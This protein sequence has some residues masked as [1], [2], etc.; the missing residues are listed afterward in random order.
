[1]RVV[2]GRAVV[3]RRPTGDCVTA[4]A[5]RNTLLP[6]RPTDELAKRAQLRCDQT[7]SGTLVQAPPN[8]ASAG[9]KARTAYSNRSNK[10]FVQS[11]PQSGENAPCRNRRA[12]PVPQC[13][14]S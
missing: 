3:G 10:Y 13:V 5:E 8:S 9:A 2:S 6:K 11:G 12:R 14:L 7:M 4:F 1:M